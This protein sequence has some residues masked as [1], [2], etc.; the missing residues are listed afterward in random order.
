VQHGGRAPDLSAG[1]E[2][3][4]VT[5]SAESDYIKPPRYIQACTSHFAQYTQIETFKT[6]QNPFFAI[7]NRFHV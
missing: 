3:T 2:R 6:T 5:L 7:I 4:K 1:F